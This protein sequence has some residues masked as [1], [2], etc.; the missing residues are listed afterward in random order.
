[1]E[2]KHA[3]H[4]SFRGAAP[5]HHALLSRCTHTGISLQTLHPRRFDRGAVLLQTPK[6][7]ITIPDPDVITVPQ[8]SNFLAPLGAE[9]LV[10]GLRERLYI[11]PKP[12]E[13]IHT[14]QRPAPKITPGDRH[15]EWHHWTADEI[16][17]RHRVVGP[18]WSTG[19]V[20]GTVQA[21]GKRIIWPSG[22]QK[23]TID[24][25]T[26][27][28]PGMAVVRESDSKAYFRT[29]EGQVISAETATVEGSAKT[30]AAK[31]LRGARCFVNH[32]E[33]SGS[34]N[35]Q[36]GHWTVYDPFC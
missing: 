23:E 20:S 7:G 25:P 36:E 9:L 17:L 28:R 14:L 3:Y 10:R 11:D 26:R 29:V 35:Y 33:K 13:D 27:L 12:L 4:A 15:I 19:I 34:Q 30:S 5:V 2:D 1:M 16:L 32:P 18:L 6:P 24:L 21:R 31:A 8:L 22:F